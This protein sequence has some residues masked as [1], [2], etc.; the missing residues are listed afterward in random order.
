MAKQQSSNV[1]DILENKLEELKKER[2]CRSS[3]RWFIA[4]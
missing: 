1:F 4:W 2:G 3:S